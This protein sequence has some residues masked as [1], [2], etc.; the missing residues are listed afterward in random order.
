MWQRKLKVELFETVKK[1]KNNSSSV[2]KTEKQLVYEEGTSENTRC[3]DLSTPDLQRARLRTAP[4]R[5]QDR[6][7]EENEHNK[8]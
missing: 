4:Q 8:K 7:G 5:E 6:D 2:E 1:R 3:R